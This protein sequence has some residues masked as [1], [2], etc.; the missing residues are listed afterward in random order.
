MYRTTALGVLADFILTQ[1]QDVDPIVSGQQRDQGLYLETA[2]Y[3][4]EFAKIQGKLP[5]PI[6]P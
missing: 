5:I 6:E 2:R 4:H 1:G 3:R